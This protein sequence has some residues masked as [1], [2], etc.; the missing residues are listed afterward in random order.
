MGSLS[1][2]NS[3]SFSLRIASMMAGPLVDFRV[4]FYPSI[5]PGMP[6]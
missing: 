1:I 3:A 2:A 4:S 5:T 6:A